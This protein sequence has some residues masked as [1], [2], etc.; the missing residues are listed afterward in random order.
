MEYSP[1]LDDSQSM[2]NLHHW[3]HDSPPMVPFQDFLGFDEPRIVVI[4][5][6]LYIGLFHDSASLVNCRVIL[7][8]YIEVP[9]LV[10]GQY[11]FKQHSY[12]HFY[13]Q[14]YWECNTSGCNYEVRT[15][16]RIHYNNNVRTIEKH[17]TC[18][19]VDIH[20]VNPVHTHDAPSPTLVD[21]LVFLADMT[22]QAVNTIEPIDLIIDTF[23]ARADVKMA[24]LLPSVEHIKKNLIHLRQNKDMYNVL[25]NPNP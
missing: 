1:S 12:R 22:E 9:M 4:K 16:E 14:I 25:L 17:T 7:P 5:R 3:F 13:E 10:V 15:E 2:E 23:Y 21:L 11:L 6:L 8:V 19:S 24:N 20:G 18:M